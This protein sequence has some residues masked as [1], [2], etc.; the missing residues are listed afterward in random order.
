MEKNYVFEGTK[1]TLQRIGKARAQR[2]YGEREL[3][4]MQLIKHAIAAVKKG[5]FEHDTTQGDDASVVE[6]AVQGDAG[7]A[8]EAS[9]DDASVNQYPK[10]REA[11]IKHFLRGVYHGLKE[12]LDN[13]ELY[14]LTNKAGMVHLSEFDKAYTEFMEKAMESGI[15]HSELPKCAVRVCPKREIVQFMVDGGPH[16]FE[17][18]YRHEDEKNKKKM[19]PAVRRG[20]T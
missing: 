11:S 15:R 19:L 13:D 8:E 4:D 3:R 16:A 5:F 9:K 1:V 6:G 7:V 14:T 20:R 10:Q 17:T 12:S 18:V 2:E